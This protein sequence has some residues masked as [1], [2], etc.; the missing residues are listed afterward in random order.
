MPSQAVEIP[1]AVLIAEIADFMVPMLD[2][3][4]ENMDFW[5]TL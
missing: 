3:N 4:Q 5:F 2:F 1:M